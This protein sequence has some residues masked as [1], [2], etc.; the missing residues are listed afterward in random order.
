MMTTESNTLT[1]L[2]C[3]SSVFRRRFFHQIC[4]QSF[5]QLQRTSILPASSLPLLLFRRCLHCKRNRGEHTFFSH[6][7]HD[8]TQDISFHPVFQAHVVLRSNFGVLA[9][10]I[11]CYSMPNFKS[12]N[13]PLRAS[14]LM[15]SEPSTIRTGLA[16]LDIGIQSFWTV[17]SVFISTCNL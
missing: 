12:L 3:S 11:S 5:L 9:E 17:G 14:S 16:S 4:R 1:H 10:L 15:A 8:W 2:F 13:P 6:L 7:F